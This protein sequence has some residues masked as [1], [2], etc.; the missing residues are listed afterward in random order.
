M[1][2]SAQSPLLKIAANEDR[3][4]GYVDA[5]RAGATEPLAQLYDET[6]AVVF[7]LALRILD[8]RADAEEIVLDVYQQLWS[9][10]QSFD[11]EDTSVWGWL[12]DRTRSRAIDRLRST[13][14][15]GRG[16]TMRTSSPAAPVQEA[17]FQDERRLV[18]N[19]LESLTPEQRQIIELSFFR[20]LSPTEV[21]EVLA[22]PLGTI[23][24]GIRLGMRRL[25]Q[26]IAP[27][28]SI[29]NTN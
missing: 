27:H 8:H 22:L 4:R 1:S 11:T 19:A 16:V 23:K 25:R 2:G 24:T 17:V 7:G 5:M 28:G 21:A 6:S 13:S 12:V 9:C 20:G 14:G 10:R 18:L 29:E 26:V 3:W 15:P